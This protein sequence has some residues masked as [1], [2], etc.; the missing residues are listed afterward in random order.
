MDACGAAEQP[1]DGWIAHI[2]SAGIGAEGRQDQPPPIADETASALMPAAPT[3]AGLG[4]KM[5]GHLTGDMALLGNMAK[6]EG[7]KAELGHGAPAQRGRWGGIVIAGDPDPV[8]GS[9]QAL[10][11]CGIG[12][13]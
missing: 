9:G 2:E 13:A 12:T 8:E 7:A 11:G 3:E 1:G 4:M 10:Q 6:D 5:A